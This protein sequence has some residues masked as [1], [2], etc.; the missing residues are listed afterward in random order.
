MTWSHELFGTPAAPPNVNKPVVVLVAPDAEKKI[1][2]DKVEWNSGWKI[3]K[4]LWRHRP[5]E[6]WIAAESTLSLCY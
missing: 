4:L 6:T 2:S 3:Y 1:T 5:K